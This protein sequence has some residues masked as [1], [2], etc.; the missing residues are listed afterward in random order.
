MCD[1]EFSTV[2]IN[3]QIKRGIIKLTFKTFTST[4]THNREDN[5]LNVYVCGYV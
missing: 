1:R 5:H 4:S 2:T 3:T